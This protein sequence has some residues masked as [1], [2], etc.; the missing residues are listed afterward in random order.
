MRNSGIAHSLASHVWLA[1]DSTCTDVGLL[2]R[3]RAIANSQEAH[4]FGFSSDHQRFI[5]IS[6][7]K[8]RD[9]VCTAKGRCTSAARGELH[10]HRHH[11][12]DMPCTILSEG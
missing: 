7:L 11:K 8:G 3:M 9:L 2:R 6:V 5:T 12:R 10:L 4:G 1:E